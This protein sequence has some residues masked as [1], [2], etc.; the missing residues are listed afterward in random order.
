[1]RERW[2]KIGSPQT[3]SQKKFVYKSFHPV[4]MNALVKHIT[5]EPITIHIHDLGENKSVHDYFAL[6]REKF[7][8]NPHNVIFDKFRKKSK[9]EKPIEWVDI[10]DNLRPIIISYIESHVFWKNNGIE[11]NKISSIL[12]TIR[13]KFLHEN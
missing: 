9:D 3:Y 12:N 7:I 10:K 5:N 11:L 13:I 2:R 1:M 8:E 6:Y 4:N